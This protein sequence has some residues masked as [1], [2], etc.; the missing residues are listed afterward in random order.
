MTAPI[1]TTSP[2]VGR[3]SV[4]EFLAGDW[5]ADAWLIDGEVVMNDPGFHH[6][7]VVGRLY[8]ALAEWCRAGPERGRAGF[9]GNWIFGPYTLLRPD[10]WWSA[11]IPTGNRRDTPPDLA[12]EVRSPSTWR[13]DLGRKREIYNE[14][15]VHELWL[16]DPPAETIVIYRRPPGATGFGPVVVAGAGDTLD[17]P[18]L[19]GFALSVDELF[20]GSG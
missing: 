11:V 14:A 4:E 18:L 13:Y 17:T 19:D 20:A 7:E 8:W 1:T 16:V 3:V 6:Q 15:G 2:P 5:P 12:V 9:G 10:V